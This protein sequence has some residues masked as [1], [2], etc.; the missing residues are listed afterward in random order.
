MKKTVKFLHSKSVLILLVVLFALTFAS[1]RL[2]YTVKNARFANEYIGVYTE[3][4]FDFKDNKSGSIDGSFKLPKCVD[5]RGLNFEVKFPAIFRNHDWDGI[6]GKMS[7]ELILE[8]EGGRLEKKGVDEL[9]DWAGIDILLTKEESKA[10][11]L[12]EAITYTFKYSD[13]Q[14]AVEPHWPSHMQ[15][16]AQ[17]KLADLNNYP[18]KYPDL[19]EAVFVVAERS[20]MKMPK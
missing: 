12:K 6:V 17:E 5:H 7:Y 14:H 3:H 15:V 18:D 20:T 13:A 4:S 8:W 16:E 2:G 11:P 10:L 19:Y 1:C 9:G